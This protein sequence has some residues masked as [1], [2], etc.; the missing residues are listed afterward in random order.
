MRVL[1]LYETSRI[2]SEKGWRDFAGSHH[3]CSS[4]L[5]EQSVW[6]VL[7]ALGDGLCF[8]VDF[9]VQFNY[10]HGYAGGAVVKVKLLDYI[11]YHLLKCHVL[12]MQ[13]SS[14]PSLSMNVSLLCFFVSLCS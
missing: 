2:F 13:T 5:T 4:V 7:A 12:P 6:P 1:W 14:C 9:V 8:V 11:Q 10:L 3:R